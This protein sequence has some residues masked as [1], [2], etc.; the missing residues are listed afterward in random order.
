M[1][2]DD[3]NMPLDA[4]LE[5]KDSKGKEYSYSLVHMG[6]LRPF[7]EEHFESDALEGY[8]G[9]KAGLKSRQLKVTPP[10]RSLHPLPPHL[11]KSGGNPVGGLSVV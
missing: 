4:N 10:P 9:L 5:S 8:G 6:G 1:H 3:N 7:W 11:Y 2:L